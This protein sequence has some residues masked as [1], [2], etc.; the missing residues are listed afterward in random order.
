MKEMSPANLDGLGV[1]GHQ[2]EK[3]M[4]WSY[5]GITFNDCMCSGTRKNWLKMK[6]SLSFPGEQVVL[7]ADDFWLESPGSP[8]GKTM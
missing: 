7:W 3:K 8:E 1:Q 2:R 5:S 4:N 6:V